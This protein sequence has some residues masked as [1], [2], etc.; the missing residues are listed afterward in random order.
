MT[1]KCFNRGV[2]MSGKREFIARANAALIEQIKNGQWSVDY[3]PSL[4]GDQ[5]VTLTS[6]AVELRAR[7]KGYDHIEYVY[8]RI[9]EEFYDYAS[10]KLDRAARRLVRKHLDQYWAAKSAEEYQKLVA[11]ALKAEG[12]P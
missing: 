2:G 7:V 4:S 3:A 10:E 9:D 11:M 8:I 6:G 5:T 1:C 12:S